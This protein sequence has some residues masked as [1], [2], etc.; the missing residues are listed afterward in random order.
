MARKPSSAEFKDASREL[1]RRLQEPIYNPFLQTH[2]GRGDLD[3]EVYLE[4]QKLL[5]A[6]TEPDELVSE[7]EL[8]FQIVH[9][10]QELW[11]KLLASESVALVRHLDRDELESADAVLGRM[12]AL[13]VQLEGGMRVLDTL[14]PG[15]FLVIRRYLGDGSGQ[16]SPGFNQL[17]LAGGFVEHALERALVRRDVTLDE[18][19]DDEATDPP[20]LRVCERMLDF[21]GNYQRWLM[22]HYL[23]VRRTIGVDRAVRALDGSSTRG[24]VGRMMRP[25]F[26]RLWQVRVELTAKWRRAGGVPPGAPR[27]GVAS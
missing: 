27:E 6:Q 3:Y 11:L 17:L 26:S 2:V 5:S 10:T 19:Y 23:L 21:D 12:I 4:T 1:A 25:L 13:S 9:Q 24:L 18:L 8:A 14:T 16:Q 22:S 15:A 7:H 20:M